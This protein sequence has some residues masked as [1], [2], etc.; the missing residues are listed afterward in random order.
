MLIGL[1]GLS[2]A[3]AEELRFDKEK[4]TEQ[5]GPICQLWQNMYKADLLK[6]IKITSADMTTADPVD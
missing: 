5:L 2:A 3:S 4:W 1:K 6:Q